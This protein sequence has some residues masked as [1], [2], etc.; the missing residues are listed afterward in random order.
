MWSL[1]LR[2]IGRTGGAEKFRASARN[3]FFDSIGQTEKHSARADVFRSS[4]KNGHWFS[5]PQKHYA[6]RMLW[7]FLE[8]RR[9]RAWSSSGCRWTSLNFTGQKRLLAQPTYAA[10]EA[11]SPRRSSRL[12]VPRQVAPRQLLF[13]E[14]AMFPARESPPI[15]LRLCCLLNAF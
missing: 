14:R 10:W 5:T 11:F 2:R 9:V 3:D 12:V 4:P 13:E 6:D 7:N 15:V 1:T 8:P